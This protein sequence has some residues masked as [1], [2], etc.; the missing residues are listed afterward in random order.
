MQATLASMWKTL[1]F[2]IPIQNV[3]LA[4]QADP[5]YTYSTLDL[6]GLGADFENNLP[7]LDSRNLRSPQNPRG[8]NQFGYAN[9]EVDRLIGLWARTPERPT[10]IEIEAQVIHRLSEDLPFLPINY[11]VETIT[12]STGTVGVLPRTAAPGAT[13]TWNVELWTRS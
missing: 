5:S 1:G 8:S 4:V 3:S 9:A 10:Q 11:R 7:R 6:S 13:N 12:A 2:T